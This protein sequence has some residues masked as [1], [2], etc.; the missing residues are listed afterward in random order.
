MDDNFFFISILS[1]PVSCDHIWNRVLTFI[2]HS[3]IVVKSMYSHKLIKI[4]FHLWV[5]QLP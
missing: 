5:S 2:P 4:G 1:L 3:E